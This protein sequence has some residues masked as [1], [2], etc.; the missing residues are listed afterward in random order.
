MEIT[1]KNIDKLNQE[2]EALKRQRRI[3]RNKLRENQKKIDSRRN[4][5]IG[6]MVVKFFPELAKIMPGTK[7]ENAEKFSGFEKFLQRVSA[8]AAI[9]ELFRE[10]ME[11]SDAQC[12][13]GQLQDERNDNNGEL[14]S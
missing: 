13:T 1:N 10:R 6:E 3:E 4:Y 7:T 8:D 2:I 14:P 5:I 12:V 9:M 11:Q